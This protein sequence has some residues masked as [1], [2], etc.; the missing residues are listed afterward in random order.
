MESATLSGKRLSMIVVDNAV[1]FMLKAYWDTQIV[2][3]GL[4]KKNDWD[5]KKGIPISISSLTRLRQ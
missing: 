5:S 2:S 1:E 4:M 3:K